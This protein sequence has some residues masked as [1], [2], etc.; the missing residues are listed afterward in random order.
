MSVPV[1]PSTES[2]AQDAPDAEVAPPQGPPAELP[3]AGPTPELLQALADWRRRLD[4]AGLACRGVAFHAGTP[5]WQLGFEPASRA[6]AEAWVALRA[7]VGDD[8]PVALGRTE[9]SASADL[10]LAIRVALPDAAPGSDEAPAAGHGIVGLLLAPPHHERTVQQVLLALG[11]LQLAL[12][13]AS[14]AHNRRAARLIEL[15]GHVAVQVDARAGAQEWINRSAAWVRE[16]LRQSDDGLPAGFTLALFEV[17][18]DVPRWWVGADTAWAERGSPAVLAASEPAQ[19]ALLEMQEVQQAPWW[20]LPLLDDGRPQA[21]LVARSDAPLPPVALEIL[22]ASATLAEPWLRQW[23]RARRNWLVHGW[24]SLRESAAK[25][26]GPGHLTWKAGAAATAVAAV[27]LLVW[28]AADRV[29]AST[30]IEGQTRQLVTAPQEGFI[31]EVKVRPGEAVAAGQLLARLDDR[32]IE[33]ERQRQASARDQAAGRLRQASAERDAAAMA[34]A[35]A[36]Q[37][38]AEAQLALTEARLARTRLTAPLAGLVVSGDWAQQ[39]G[40]PVEAGKEM[41]E[42][43]AGDGWRVVLHVPDADIVR[44]RV[45]QQGQIRLAGRPQETHAFEVLRLTAT[46][47]V[48]DSVNGFRVEARWLGEPPPL[49]PGMQG[50]GKIEVG[51]AP[52]LVQWTRPSLNWL[53]LKLWRW[54]P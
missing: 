4:A 41:F 28:P 8:Q 43:A 52:L 53:R 15:L 13:S 33:L 42:I 6:V 2:L 3:P 47:S 31:A 44:V 25:V 17:R 38:S 11:W 24:D 45:G 46:A 49:S 32:E 35:A 39:L 30:V 34:L 1:K 5:A 51:H 50:V 22:R 26:A 10:M 29:S 36:E 16:E 14:L 19:R 9:H 23:R 54:M 37:R 18:G 21:V 7:R 27:A 40:G 12:A 48:Q 20:A